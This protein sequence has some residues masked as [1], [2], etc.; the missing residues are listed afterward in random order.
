MDARVPGL[1]LAHARES[2]L[3]GQP[4]VVRV[5]RHSALFNRQLLGSVSLGFDAVRTL[6]PAE[7]IGLRLWYVRVLAPAPQ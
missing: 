3:L 6:D 5:R 7:R 1:S 4:L 2:A